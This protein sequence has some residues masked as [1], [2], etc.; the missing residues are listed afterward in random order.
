[1]YNMSEN[2]PTNFAFDGENCLLVVLP[3]ENDD[4]HL[5]NSPNSDTQIEIN[6]DAQIQITTQPDEEEY[7][8]SE[9]SQE[10]MAKQRIAVTPKTSIK[11]SEWAMNRFNEFLTR[12]KI[13]VDL[14]TI[15]PE[16]L[17]PILRRF[18]SQVKNQTYYFHMSTLFPYIN[19]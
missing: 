6:T 5:H 8:I 18:Y 16:S 10:Q 14:K 15:N 9:L 2:N 1:M 13:T 17:A 19:K 11:S 12:K 7:S 3:D 4:E